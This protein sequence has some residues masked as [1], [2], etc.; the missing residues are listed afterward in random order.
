MAKFWRAA[1]SEALAKEGV[2]GFVPPACRGSHRRTPMHRPLPLL[3]ALACAVPFVPAGEGS[4]YLLFEGGPDGKYSAMHFAR[5]NLS[6]I[7]QGEPT[8]DGAVPDW[9]R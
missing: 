9:V 7:L 4:I 5:L 3:L 1:P 6:W 8:G 2:F